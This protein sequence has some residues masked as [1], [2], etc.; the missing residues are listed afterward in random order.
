MEKPNL[1]L[2]VDDDEISNFINETVLNNNLKNTEIHS[3]I[4]PI[5]ALTFLKNT[6]DQNPKSTLLF[7]DINM[8]QMSGWEVLDELMEIK[9]I[10]NFLK[11][12]MISSSI[13]N[14]DKK[15]SRENSLVADFISKPL[16]NDYI[17]NLIS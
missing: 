1:V 2:L 11:V 10:H 15:K 6:F 17:K 13:D 3:F 8:P 16:S 7:L 5:E 12:I 14:T 9:E 4:D